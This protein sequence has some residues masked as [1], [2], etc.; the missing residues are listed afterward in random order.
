MEENQMSQIETLLKNQA[1]PSS[2]S[3]SFSSPREVGTN[4]ALLTLSLFPLLSSYLLSMW[5]ENF[6]RKEHWR[7]KKE[8]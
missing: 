3:F 5:M 1:V 8:E 4:W 2:F 7:E 6:G